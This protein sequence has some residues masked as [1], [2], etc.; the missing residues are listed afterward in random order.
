VEVDSL[1]VLPDSVIHFEVAPSTPEDESLSIQ[2][3]VDWEVLREGEVWHWIGRSA[4]LKVPSTIDDGTGYSGWWQ[5]QI[6]QSRAIP[7][8][9]RRG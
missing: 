3:L 7:L 1:D 8:S 2:W 9:A 4:P 6:F 5:S